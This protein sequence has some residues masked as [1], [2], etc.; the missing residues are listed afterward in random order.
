VTGGG[1]RR[2]V[3]FTAQHL[4][5]DHAVNEYRRLGVRGSLQVGAPFVVHDATQGIPE[6]PIGPIK[7]VRGPR[8]GPGEIRRHSRILTALTGKYQGHGRREGQS[9]PANHFRGYSATGRTARPL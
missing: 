3:N 8:N 1:D 6:N 7:D 4:Q 2:R 9:L 5:E